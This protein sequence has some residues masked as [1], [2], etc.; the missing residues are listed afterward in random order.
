MKTERL[1]L[2]SLV[3]LSSVLF[4]LNYKLVRLVLAGCKNCLT[5]TIYKFA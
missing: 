5:I 2:A 3:L 1:E 4:A